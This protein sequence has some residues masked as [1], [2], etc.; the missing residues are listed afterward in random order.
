MAY[1]QMIGVFVSLMMEMSSAM[2]PLSPLDIPSHSSMMTHVLFLPPPPTEEGA[3]G[4][5]PADGPKKP[6]SVWFLVRKSDSLSPLPLRC[7]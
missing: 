2:P 7:G 5:L 3:A 6:A 4:A 1:A